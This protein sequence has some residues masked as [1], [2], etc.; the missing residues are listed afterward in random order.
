MFEK[1]YIFIFCCLLFLCY[2]NM[3]FAQTLSNNGFDEQ[4]LQ[5]R[6]KQLSEFFERFNSEGVFSNDESETKDTILLRKKS[7]LSLFEKKLITNKVFNKTIKSFVNQVVD[8]ISPQYLKYEDSAWI[9]QV[10]CNVSYNGKDNKIRLFLKTEKIREREY[11]WVIIGVNADFLNIKQKETQQIRMIS[12]VD[13]EL[14]FMSL[15]DVT[16]KRNKKYCTQYA[17]KKYEVDKISILFFLIYNSKLTIN[18]TQDVKYH[19]LQIP[20]YIFTVS[21]TIDKT[22][23]DGW[24]ITH[25]QQV[26]KK[27]KEEYIHQLF[28]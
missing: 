8:S 17:N 2:G 28:F 7:I 18:S 1:K 3:S 15:W 5:I 4:K 24:L 26:N 10:D 12:P 20:N 6:V 21:K 11:K 16:S 27:E 13:N 14:S 9:A 22:A 19:F 25:I 23:Y